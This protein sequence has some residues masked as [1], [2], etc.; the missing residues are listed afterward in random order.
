MDQTG[1]S[2]AAQQRRGC[3]PV[4]QEEEQEGCCRGVNLPSRSST[5]GPGRWGTRT[6]ASI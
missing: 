4:R 3:R 6:L 5:T 2:P 1:G